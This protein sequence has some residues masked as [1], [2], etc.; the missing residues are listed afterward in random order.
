[1]HSEYLTVLLRTTGGDPLKV[2]ARCIFTKPKLDSDDHEF[3]Y[4]HIEA[5]PWDLLVRWLAM[6][7]PRSQPIVEALLAARST[8]SDMQNLAT[9]AALSPWPAWIDE[10]ACEEL[11]AR[12]WEALE[13]GLWWHFARH[14]KGMSPL[15]QAALR[16]HQDCGLA[17]RLF[18][19]RR[20]ERA[21]LAALRSAART[22]GLLLHARELW[23]FGVDEP[24]PGTA[25]F[26]L[27]QRAS[28]LIWM[29]QRG[30][31]DRLSPEDALPEEVRFATE[32]G[33]WRPGLDQFFLKLALRWPGAGAPRAR[34]WYVAQF[35][36]AA[37][38]GARWAH[39]VGELVPRSDLRALPEVSQGHTG[40]DKRL[41]E[42][43]L[44][45]IAE[46]SLAGPEVA[47][48][49]GLSVLASLERR[50]GGAWERA[51]RYLDRCLEDDRLLENDVQAQGRLRE[52]LMDVE[53]F[54]RADPPTVV[55]QILF[56]AP[57]PEDADEEFEAR[58]RGYSERFIQRGL[59]AGAA[60]WRP[61]SRSLFRRIAS[62]PLTTA[63]ANRLLAMVLDDPDLRGSVEASELNA[64]VLAADPLPPERLPAPDAFLSR[65]WSEE[66]I[67][68]YRQLG[69]TAAEPRLTAWVRAPL[70]G[71]ED[72]W[73][74]APSEPRILE[75]LRRAQAAG[76]LT[77]ELRAELAAHSRGLPMLDL[78]SLHRDAP[79]LVDEDALQAIAH[80]R[81][82]KDPADPWASYDE[83]RLPACLRP[84]VRQRAQ[85]I[86]DEREFLAL[87][88]WLGANQEPPAD[89]VTLLLDRVARRP[90]TEP[91]MRWLS[92]VLSSRTLWE[93]Q[94]P[95][96][97]DALVKAEAWDAIYHLVWSPTRRVG[98]EAEAWPSQGIVAAIHEALALPLLRRLEEALESA[99]AQAAR[100][101]LQALATL[102]PTPR[103]GKKLRALGRRPAPSE[104]VAD[105]L[106]LNLRLLRKGTMRE[107]TLLDVNAA[108]AFLSEPNPG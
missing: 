97:M 98:P 81:A 36:A 72:D 9:E 88:R 48:W 103:L 31:L 53:A 44:G 64:L 14:L 58:L 50:E 57:V 85:A 56:K 101:T 61:L 65:R 77:P 41:A 16:E 86:A 55:W 47:P 32:E 108:L 3:L 13:P 42:E 27:R 100:A 87:V 6:K 62:F 10:G 4:Q 40:G 93:R 73:G 92:G 71:A 104:D 21:C 59:R 28:V 70:D 79:S 7:P 11:A 95:R 33:G 39:L 69:G 45:E 22:G 107:A 102:H 2:A 43:V 89:L 12:S 29:E 90:A 60:F 8:P 80:E 18:P 25:A 5:L 19:H 76:A 105:L 54:P 52:A 34:A 37:R 66:T 68:A 84:A 91:L 51:F 99:N 17:A 30:F 38:R 20:D 15:F 75:T 49:W 63:R 82:G 35:L 23:S 106:Q 67:A 94:G 78:I 1:M 26:T 74:A 46:A 24:S 83:A 96:V